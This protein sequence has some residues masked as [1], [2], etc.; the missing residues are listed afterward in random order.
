VRADGYK[1][2]DGVP[3]PPHRPNTTSVADVIRML[4][5]GQSVL[6]AQYKS[7]ANAGACRMAIA[8]HKDRHY[9]MR[10]VD[11]GVRLWRVS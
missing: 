3:I 11:G 9:V 4:E 1:I 5:P 6:F 8:T 10:T 2:E 7:T